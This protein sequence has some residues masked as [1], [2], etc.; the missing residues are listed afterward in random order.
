MNDTRSGRAEPLSP[1]DRRRSI[2]GAVVPLLLEKGWSVTTREMAEAAGV[3]EGTIFRVFP[4]KHALLHEAMRAT[5]D[6]GPIVARLNAIDAA[7]PVGD[8]LR[9]AV[10]ILLEMVDEMVTL[11]SI[12]HG[13]PREEKPTRAAPTECVEEA[14]SKIQ[15]ALIA[16]FARHRDRLRVEPRQAAAVTYALIVATAHPV[17][18][19]GGRL[20]EREIVDVLVGGI[21]EQDGM[22]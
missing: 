3:A 17:I 22:S 13:M 9:A 21:V 7:A 10:G 2:I 16:L 11:M 14:N 4:D 20:S 18:T 19:P 1:E 6:A 8:Q 12:M 5:M 15:A